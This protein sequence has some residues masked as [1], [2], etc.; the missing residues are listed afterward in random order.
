M[1]VLGLLNHFNNISSHELNE[2]EKQS[3]DIGAC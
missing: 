3:E 2:M 1:Q